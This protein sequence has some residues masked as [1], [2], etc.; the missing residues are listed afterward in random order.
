M[1]LGNFGFQWWGKVVF[2]VGRI[3]EVGTECRL[4]GTRALLATTRDM[5]S[6][7]VADRVSKLL[8]S[9]GIA[10][11]RFDDVEPDPTCVAVDQA[12]QVA[13]ADRC[14]VVVG[15]GGGS[16]LDF[17]KGVA[18]AAGHPSPIWDYVNYTGASAKPVTAAALPSLAIPTT[19]GTGAEVTQGVV[20]HNPETH[21]K[22]ALLSPY[23]FPKAAVVDPELSYTMPPK[24]T[25]MTGFDALTHGI[26]AFLN[27]GRRS[28]VSDLV[29]MENVRTVTTFLPRV[30]D[31][32]DDL[33][34]RQQMAWAGTLGG[35]SIALAGATI[36]HAMGLPLG[37]RLNVAHGLG[38]SRLLPV[39]LD[40]SCE[41]Q[42]ERCAALADVVG[43]SRPGM[44]IAAKAKVLGPWLRDFARRIGLARLWTG[45]GIDDAMLDLL[46]EDVFA[47]MGRPIQQHRP[48]FTPEQIRRQFAEAL[49]NS[50]QS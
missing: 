47:Y 9:A 14:E 6:L 21:M 45:E 37:A 39:V 3:E 27:A 28:P 31:R 44:D 19:A 33:E 4:L 12:S 38:L 10:V 13:R 35:M 41:T 34:A 20:L 5:V 50:G 22:A 43:A 7:G 17:A 23:A 8:E 15:L 40:H 30:V 26:E 16:A 24:V 36:A 2:G 11:T 25:A 29:A 1:A 42:P 32:G 18:V 46:T 48:V 49:Q